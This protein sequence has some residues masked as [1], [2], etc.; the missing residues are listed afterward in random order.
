MSLFVVGVEGSCEESSL[1]HH[2]QSEWL[3]AAQVAAQV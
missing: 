3:T 2:V 1:V